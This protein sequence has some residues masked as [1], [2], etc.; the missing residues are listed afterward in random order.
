MRSNFNVKLF[1][2]W[3]KKNYG[4]T[5]AEAPINSMTPVV[6]K[7]PDGKQEYIFIAKAEEWI[8]EPLKDKTIEDKVP[9]GVKAYMEDDNLIW[10]FNIDPDISL[11]SVIP[12]DI[13]KEFLIGI[14]M[15]D[16]LTVVIV[17]HITMNIVWMTND[18]PFWQVKDQFKVFFEY[19]NL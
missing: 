9:M 18:Y 19:F 13:A 14:K 12:H 10:G 6:G 11:E 2:Q 1:E 7:L 5:I 15:Q 4:E 17:N 3:I 16:K 8:Y